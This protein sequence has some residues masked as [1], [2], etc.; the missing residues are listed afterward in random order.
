M[1]TCYRRFIE[2]GP[3][4]SASN[5]VVL[6][7]GGADVNGS[8]R[9]IFD[10]SQFTYIGADLAAGEG[11]SII[12]EDPYKLPLDDA[13]IDIVLSGQMLEHCEF[14]WLSF[15]EMVRV[16]KPGGYIFLIAPS[17]G[18]IH[19]CPV[20][21]YRFYPDAY[22]ALAKYANCRLLDVWHDERG[23]WKDLVGV[24]RRHTV[25]RPVISKAPVASVVYDVAASPIGTP[26]EEAIRGDVPYLDVLASLHRDLEPSLYLELGVRRGR[27]LK[28]AQCQAVGVDPKPQIAVVLPDTTRVLPMTSDEFFSGLAKQVLPK[29]PDLVFIDGMHLFEYAL[30]DFMHAE[31]LAA[32]NTLVVFDDIFPNH[33]AQAARVR[34]TRVWTGDVWKIYFCLREWRRDLFILPVN[35]SPAGLLLVAGLDHDNRVLWDKYNGIVRVNT[36]EEIGVPV[37]ILERV[38]AK[39]ADSPVLSRLAGV[40]NAV[41]AGGESPSRVVDALRASLSGASPV[42]PIRIDQ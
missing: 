15:A 12:L 31:R 23:P 3:L 1:R 41:R 37:E 35:A 25:P 34:R 10:Q 19:R 6:D 2:S 5:V 42:A 8:Y 39:A 18:P 16:L 11:V 7:I 26:G 24:F 40:L 17:A 13:T 28:L 36:K 29:S 32:P 30:R 33:P 38:G 14:F 21:C 4:A 22:A 27:S 20:D 9:E